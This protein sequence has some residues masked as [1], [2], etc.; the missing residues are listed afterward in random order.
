MKK[1]ILHHLVFCTKESQNT[2]V[3][4]LNK[5]VFFLIKTRHFVKG[6]ENWSDHLGSQQTASSNFVLYSASLEMQVS[7]RMVVTTVNCILVLPNQRVNLKPHNFITMKVNSVHRK[8][9]WNSLYFV[10]FD[11][12]KS[13]TALAMVRHQ[14]AGLI[15]VNNVR[16]SFFYRDKSFF[17]PR[18]QL[19]VHNDVVRK[20]KDDTA[21][22]HQ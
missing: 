15:S 12:L 1:N 10:H 20:V 8:C 21:F 2:H 18:S 16:I 5:T 4:F 3:N 7:S 22:N 14:Q 6:G 13:T 11:M 17:T 19:A 9:I